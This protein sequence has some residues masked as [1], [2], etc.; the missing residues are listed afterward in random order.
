MKSDL[1]KDQTIVEELNLC[2]RCY[3]SLEKTELKGVYKCP[4]CKVVV[5]Q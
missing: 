3:V 4:V 1:P 5:E 2:I